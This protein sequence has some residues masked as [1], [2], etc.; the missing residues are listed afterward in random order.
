MNAGQ[1]T[2]TKI[3]FDYDLK[4]CSCAEAEGRRAVLSAEEDGFDSELTCSDNGGLLSVILGPQRKSEP[5]WG[6]A[7][8]LY[9]TDS[10]AYAERLRRGG[11]AVCGW[12]HEGNRQET[13]EGIRYIVM[14]PDQLEADSYCKIWQRIRHLP[15]TIL[16]TERMIVRELTPSDL[17]DLY[18]LY[19]EKAL[20][21]LMPLSK[22]H[23]EEASYLASYIEKVY[24]FYGYGSWALIEKATGGLIGRAGFTPPAHQGE[25]DEIGYLIRSDKR[26]LGYASEAVRAILE[27]GRKYLGI[28]DVLALIQKDN[29]ASIHLARSLGFVPDGMQQSEGRICIRYI[30]HLQ[31]N[32]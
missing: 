25:P 16:Q 6:A 17:P 10:T 18:R 19:D 26:S 14:E 31:Q 23:E 24:G 1:K 2:L 3:I 5:A 11:F 12:R 8:P 15:W 20:R 22:N 27:Y 4:Y 28:D 21:Y 30:R 29:E 13:F 7:D 32:R 9:V